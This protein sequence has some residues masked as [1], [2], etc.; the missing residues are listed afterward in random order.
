[1]TVT[2]LRHQLEVL[3]TRG[4]GGAPI[5]VCVA[6]DQAPEFEYQAA[7]SARVLRKTTTTPIAKGLRPLPVVVIE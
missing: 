2:E 6:I 4:L 5:A 3:E 7:S 1:M